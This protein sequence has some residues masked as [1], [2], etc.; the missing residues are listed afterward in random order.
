MLSLLYVYCV[1]LFC[2][3]PICLLDIFIVSPYYFPCLQR[4]LRCLS[5][6]VSSLFSLLSPFACTNDAECAAAAAE[7]A[8]ATGY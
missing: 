7:A 6:F 1:S 2:L 4:Y 8:A 3:S 5:L